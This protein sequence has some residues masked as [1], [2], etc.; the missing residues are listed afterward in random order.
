MATTVICI[1]F[2]LRGLR[3]MEVIGLEFKRIQGHA[4]VPLGCTQEGL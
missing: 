3:G 2:G 4:N 1:D